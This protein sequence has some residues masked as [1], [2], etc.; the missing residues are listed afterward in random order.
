MVRRAPRPT[1]RRRRLLNLAF[2]LAAAVSL[3]LCAATLALWVRSRFVHDRLEWE[4]RDERACVQRRS[5]LQVS[6]GSLGIQHYREAYIGATPSVFNTFG[7]RTGFRWQGA[8]PHDV[9]PYG[10]AQAWRQRFGFLWERERWE[11]AEPGGVASYAHT[12]VVL[13]IVLPIALTAV[14]P[15]LAAHRR[16]QRSKR[17]AGLCPTCG[18]DLRATPER[19]PECGT[20]CAPAA[21]TAPAR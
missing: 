13:P 21:T 7:G 5:Y 17:I 8:P 14:L 6:L 16:Y 4:V 9:G 2:K 12:Y 20:T 18:Y 15:T 11:R 19:C 10:P 3:V 1:P